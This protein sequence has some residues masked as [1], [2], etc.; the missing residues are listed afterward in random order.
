MTTTQQPNN[1][2]KTTNN[3]EPGAAIYSKRVLSIYDLLVIGF[4]NRFAWRCPS[5]KILD[6]YNE[7]ITG[8][9]LD[10]G[11]GTGWFLDNCTFPTPNPLI[12]LA[13]LN[14]NSLEKAARRLRRYRPS[15]HNINVLQ[16]F[17]V[18]PAGFD[19]IAINYVLHCLPGTMQ[20]KGVVFHHLKAMLNPKGGVIFGATILG[21]GAQHN[22]LA[23]ALMLLYNAKGIFCNH[24][25]NAWDFE[26]VLKANFYE[27]DIRTVGSVAFFV[28]KT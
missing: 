12:A 20:S 7:H 19:S 16:P 5:R 10:V 13:D 18:R 3:Q 14:P 26:R 17:W 28:G 1:K 23:E 15:T 4:S 11:V 27:Y 24:W 25:D 9:H 8:K 6:F 22:L 21:Q 2:H